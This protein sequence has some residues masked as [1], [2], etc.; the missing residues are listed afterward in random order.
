MDHRELQK[1][2]AD[3]PE[4]VS[5]E[6]SKG[7][8]GTAG[9]VTAEIKVEETFEKIHT[10]EKSNKCNQWAEVNRLGGHRAAGEDTDETKIE[11][12]DH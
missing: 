6:K 12:Q 9:E 4:G 11:D 2:F 1:R 8:Q 3:W 10:G 5:R 7:E